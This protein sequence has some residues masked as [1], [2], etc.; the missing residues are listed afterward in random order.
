MHAAPTLLRLAI[1]VSA[2]DEFG[3][4]NCDNS[5]LNEEEEEE[6]E[7]DVI[8]GRYLFILRCVA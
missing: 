2:I 5:I 1:N 4:I 8:F 7:E 3:S 6:E